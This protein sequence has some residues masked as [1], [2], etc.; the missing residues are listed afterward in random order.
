MP[1]CRVARIAAWVCNIFYEILVKYKP[2]MLGPVEMLKHKI[3]QSR[4]YQLA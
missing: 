3:Q 4:D 2:P 1:C